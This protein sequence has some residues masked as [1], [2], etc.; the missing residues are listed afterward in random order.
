MRDTQIPNHFGQIFLNSRFHVLITRCKIREKFLIELIRSESLELQ[1]RLNGAD[2]GCDVV[3]QM[4]NDQGC[5]THKSL[6]QLCLFPQLCLH[7]VLRVSEFELVPVHTV[8][9]LITLLRNALG[10][11]SSA[12]CVLLSDQVD[13]ERV[14]L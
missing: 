1:S 12:T 3:T 6:L 2:E 7:F 11:G 8:V 9:F 4:R 10:L 13:L 14:Y 5:F